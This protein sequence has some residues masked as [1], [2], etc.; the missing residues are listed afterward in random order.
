MLIL[1]RKPGE[2]III[3]DH[4]TITILGVRG[5]QVRLGVEA[6]LEISVHRE[7]IYNR[8]QKEKVRQKTQVHEVAVETEEGSD[9]AE[10]TSGA[11]I[12]SG[13]SLNQGQ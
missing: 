12:A 6:P 11:D 10:D 1:T 8:I 3:G 4:V 5:N 13:D 2:S 9:G 7:E